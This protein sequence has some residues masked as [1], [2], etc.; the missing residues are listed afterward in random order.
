MKDQRHREIVELAPFPRRFLTHRDFAD[1]SIEPSITGSTTATSLL[2][3]WVI[4]HIVV[5]AIT[6]YYAVTT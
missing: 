3:L 6:A 2:E 4:A 1:I 5:Q